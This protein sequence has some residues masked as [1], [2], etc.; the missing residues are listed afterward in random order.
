MDITAPALG[1]G[2]TEGTLATWLVVFGQTVAKGDLVA[3]IE[4]DE[5]VFEVTAPVSGRMSEFLVRAGEV[6]RAGMVIG[7]MKT[8]ALAS[9]PETDSADGQ[10]PSAGSV[11]GPL[12]FVSHATADAQTAQSLVAQMEAAGTACWIAPRDVRPG[13]DYRIEIMEALGGCRSVLLLVSA[14]SNASAHVL[15]EVT[16]AEQRHKRIVPLRLDETP[17]RPELEYFLQAVH[18]ARYPLDIDTLSRA[19]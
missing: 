14:A 1:E 7:R 19:L 16:V 5:V 2:L 12:V 4:T 10:P 3:E 9:R 8:A 6:V 18:W 17:L 13:H 11:T 15:R